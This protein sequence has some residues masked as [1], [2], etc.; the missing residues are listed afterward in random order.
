MGENAAPNV[1]RLSAT[2]VGG[3]VS[4]PAQQCAGAFILPVCRETARAAAAAKRSAQ[5]PTSPSCGDL[6]NGV[7]ATFSFLNYF[8]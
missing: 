2:P 3:H 5:L 6:I 8:Q 7:I 1:R 4:A